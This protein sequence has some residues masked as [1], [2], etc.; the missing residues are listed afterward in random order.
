MSRLLSF[1]LV[2]SCVL[3][4]DV[5]VAAPASGIACFAGS[6]NHD[7]TVLVD[8]RKVADVPKLAYGAALPRVDVAVPA[9]AHTVGFLLASKDKPTELTVTVRE[10]EV[11]V[12]TTAGRALDLVGRVQAAE[13][14]AA[15]ATA[16]LTIVSN[17]GDVRVAVNGERGAIVVPAAKDGAPA[18]ATA[19]LPAGIVLLQ[20][21]FTAS[22]WGSRYTAVW[23]RPD[24]ETVLRMDPFQ[25]ERLDAGAVAVARVEVTAWSPSVVVVVDG[26]NTGLLPTAKGEQT[27]PPAVFT[28]LPGKLPIEVNGSFQKLSDATLEV[29]AGERV[30]AVV[31]NGTW[32][33]ER[34]EAPAVQGVAP[35]GEPIRL[36]PAR[37]PLRRPTPAAKPPTRRR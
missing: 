8:G 31:D 11:V 17:T 33:V 5:A 16:T 2:A 10:G 15:D 4:A 22:P 18:R 23:L 24:Q 9:G 36:A 12:V 25:T 26:V 37:Q 27:Y 13:P 20:S 14:V 3:I 1:A 29:T 32:K 35:P 7:A 28:V 21:N 19:T 30:F 6:S 34:R